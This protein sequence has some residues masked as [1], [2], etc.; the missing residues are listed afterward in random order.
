MAT[1]TQTQQTSAPK[2]QAQR[3]AAPQQ[4][5]A[6]VE[7][8][9]NGERGLNRCFFIGRLGADPVMKYTSAGIA[10]TTASL[11][12]KSYPTAT[13]PDWIK[14]RFWRGAAETV[15]QYAQRG[16]KLHVEGK[17]RISSYTDKDGVVR[18]THVIDVDEFMFL[19]DSA[20]QV[21]GVRDETEALDE[22][23]LDGLDEIV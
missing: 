13:K 14:L 8:T 11:A 22:A 9:S 12:V 3:Q 7:R 16:S 23:D 21:R 2:Q 18:A 15:N 17:L 6:P 19:G 5:Q 10:V 20:H 4:A 1:R